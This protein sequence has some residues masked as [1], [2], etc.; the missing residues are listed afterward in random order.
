[1]KSRLHFRTASFPVALSLLIVLIAGCG[2][3]TGL[4]AATVAS[5]MVQPGGPTE[6]AILETGTAGVTPVVTPRG[7]NL[8]ASEP[9]TVRLASGQL[10]LVEFFRF[11]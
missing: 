8:V 1:M 10:Q 3:A 4:P 6:D 7:P 9:S 2:P 5:P 11:T